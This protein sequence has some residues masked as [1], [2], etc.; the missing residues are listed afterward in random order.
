M[1]NTAMAEMKVVRRLSV[2]A[3]IT[4]GISLGLC[5]DAV[6]WDEGVWVCGAGA[7]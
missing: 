5:C 7:R 1:T 3:L 4:S 6:C 2:Y